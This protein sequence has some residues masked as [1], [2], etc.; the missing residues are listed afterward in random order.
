MN[1]PALSCR[2]YRFAPA[3]ISHCVWLYVR[4]LLRQRDIEVIMAKRGVIVTHE[5]IR[6]WCETSG[7]DYANRIRAKRGKRDDTWHLDEVF[8]KI[9]GRLQ[10]LWHVVDQDDSELNILVQPR[11]HKKPG[12]LF[13]K[14]L[15]RQMKYEP[16]LVVTEKLA[17]YRAPCPELLTNAEHRREKV[18]P[19]RSSLRPWR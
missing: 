6:T 10:Y 15:I 18:A 2:G 9:T 4:C 8:V 14:K 12:A 17:G 3:V 5:S 7:Q 13:F 16:R 1:K 11:R 19:A